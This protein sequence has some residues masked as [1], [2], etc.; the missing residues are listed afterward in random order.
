MDKGF[1]SPSYIAINLFLKGEGYHTKNTGKHILPG[2]FEVA[3]LK[4]SF[5][6]TYGI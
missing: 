2:V 6:Q 3:N 1:H 4:E 5:T